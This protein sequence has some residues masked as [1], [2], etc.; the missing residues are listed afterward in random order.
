[1]IRSKDEALRVLLLIGTP[2]L[3]KKAAAL[4]EAAQVPVLHSFRARGTATKE[5]ADMLGVGSVEKEVLLGVLPGSQA[6][7]L[8][9]QMGKQL[10]LGFPNTG[11]AFTIALTGVSSRLYNLVNAKN[12]GEEDSA[13]RKVG[14]MAVGNMTESGY[15]L[16]MVIV[17][18]GYSEEVM[19]AARP[20]GATGGTVFH[21]R[22]VGVEEAMKFWGISVQQE[23]EI[24]LV[25]VDKAKKRDI[26]QAINEKC[27]MQSAA[28][29]VV[30]SLP[31]EDVAGMD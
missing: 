23:R 1:M 21:S 28:H 17:N 13:E 12:A 16:I 15:S 9:R 27:G 30:M 24:L 18:Q 2:K 31:V 10:H 20:R 25:L 11:V 22:R 8:V 7:L 26:L 19:S 29:G 3:T 14:D 4:C 6:G 5:I